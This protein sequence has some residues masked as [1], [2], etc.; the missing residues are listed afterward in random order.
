[1]NKTLS[2]HE[3]EFAFTSLDLYQSSNVSDVHNFHKHY[4]LYGGYIEIAVAT[5]IYGFN[6]H[7]FFVS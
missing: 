1:M 7:V 2:M 6:V 5:E 4:F 3:Y